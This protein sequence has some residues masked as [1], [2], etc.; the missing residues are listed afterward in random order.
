MD[1]KKEKKKTENILYYNKTIKH[2]KMCGMKVKHRLEGIIILNIYSRK[3]EF[4]S[5]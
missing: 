1:T 3:E 5:Q 4:T 2:H